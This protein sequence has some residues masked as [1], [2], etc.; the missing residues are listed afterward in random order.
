MRWILTDEGEF[1]EM[2]EQGEVGKFGD[3]MALLFP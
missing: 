3:S 1:I 2:E